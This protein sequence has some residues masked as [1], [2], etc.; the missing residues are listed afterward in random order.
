MT[1]SRPPWIACLMA[2]KLAAYHWRGPQPIQQCDQVWHAMAHHS[3]QQH[4]SSPHA[5]HHGVVGILVHE[6]IQR[7][8]AA[9]SQQLHIAGLRVDGAAAEGQCGCACRRFMAGQQG[10]C[11]Q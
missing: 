9:H 10:W 4:C 2:C 6:A 7:R 8:E 3:R 5:L 1:L 11:M